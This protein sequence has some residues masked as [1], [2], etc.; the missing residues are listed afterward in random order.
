MLP[1]E[2]HR[3]AD[4]RTMSVCKEPPS[5]VVLGFFAISQHCID[6]GRLPDTDRSRLPRKPTVSA[7]YL[8]M[9]GVMTSLQGRG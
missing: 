1:F 5:N 8:S 7:I 4:A 2:A 6:V 3:H 9:V